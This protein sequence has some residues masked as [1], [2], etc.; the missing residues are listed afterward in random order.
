MKHSVMHVKSVA[1]P[2]E[3]VVDDSAS[4]QQIICMY[5]KALIYYACCCKSYKI[6]Q[7]IQKIVV[8][9]THRSVVCEVILGGPEQRDET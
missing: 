1:R 4:I 7:I 3:G 6:I 9:E 2:G 5:I 8:F